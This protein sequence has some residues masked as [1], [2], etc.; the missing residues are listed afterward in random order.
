[1]LRQEKAFCMEGNAAMIFNRFLILSQ[2]KN[3]SFDLITR[4]SYLILMGQ[5]V[6]MTRA[7]KMTHSLLS[8]VLANFCLVLAVTW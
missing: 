3:V 4:Y 5:G 7:F 8:A 1:M 2:L 6:G